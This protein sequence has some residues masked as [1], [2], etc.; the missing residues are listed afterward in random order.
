MSASDGPEIARRNFPPLLEDS[1][2]QGPQRFGVKDAFVNLRDRERVESEYNWFRYSGFAF[3]WLLI[4]FVSAVGLLCMTSWQAD[5]R[6]II[7]RGLARDGTPRRIEIDDD[8]LYE[9]GLPERNTNMRLFTSFFGLGAVLIAV[10]NLHAAPGIGLRRVLNLV[11][12]LLT[13]TSVVFAAL[14]FTFDEDRRGNARDCY[15]WSQNDPIQCDKNTYAINFLI[16][17]E[18]GVMIFGSLFLMWI[19]YT[20]FTNEF[21]YAPRGWK[22]KREEQEQIGTPVQPFDM[23]ELQWDAEEKTPAPWHSQDPYLKSPDVQY[24][25][26]S[27]ALITMSIFGFLCALMCIVTWNVD[28]NG[29]WVQSYVNAD[30]SIERPGWERQ[31]T[32]LRFVVSLGVVTSVLLN[33]LPVRRR[34]YA[35]VIAF[36]DFCLAI[37]A[38]TAFIVDIADLTD[39]QDQACPLRRDGTPYNCTN[40]QFAFTVFLDIWL[41]VALLAYVVLEFV[42]RKQCPYCRRKYSIFEAHSA[43]QCSRRPVTCEVM[44]NGSMSAAEY[45]YLHKHIVGID[46]V[47]CEFCGQT[48]VDM[49]IAEHKAK[50]G[51]VAVACS[52][53]N[54]FFRREDMADHVVVCGWRPISCDKCGAIFKKRDAQAHAAVCPERKVTCPE[55]DEI[56]L[57]GALQEHLE[58]YC[59]KR[60]VQCEL[61]LQDVPYFKLERHQHTECINRLVRCHMCGGDFPAGE[62]DIH[63]A[64]CNMRPVPCPH[65]G[66]NLNGGQHPSDPNMC[67]E[68][69]LEECPV[70]GQMIKHRDMEAHLAK[71]RLKPHLGVHL[72]E[73]DNPRNP[74]FRDV[75]VSATTAGAPAERAG[76]LQHDHILKWAGPDKFQNNTIV[77]DVIRNKEDFGRRL[78][79]STYNDQVVLTIH[80][81]NVGEKQ[82]AIIVGG[83]EV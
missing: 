30:G 27:L 53:C 80:R 3:P 70:T 28:H 54:E 24:V 1:S 66:K 49:D 22:A 12:A 82:I 41:F 67:P 77:E 60:L 40:D 29:V 33:L 81:D 18:L 56:V 38:L 52:M 6:N 55:C 79:A 44:Q 58:L 19:V 5:T 74:A 13:M 15:Q 32:L 4:I 25:H 50:C 43:R 45:V 48:F 20:T 2:I 36:V 57:H 10:L 71:Q 37:L 47:E 59:P 46:R 51:K 64:H 9:G 42:A 76:L 14:A 26:R 68:I 75:L 78:Q 17:Q 62:I 72:I 21:A 8:R 69:Q 31:N 39:A 73:M 23:E 35:L 7:F 34:N 11:V 63:M 61:C 83:Q 16:V 65:C